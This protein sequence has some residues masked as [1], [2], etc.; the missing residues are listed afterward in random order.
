MDFQ[1]GDVF[2]N[3]KKDAGLQRTVELVINSILIVLFVL[4]IGRT[5]VIDIMDTSEQKDELEAIATQLTAKAE[6]IRTAE[7][8]LASYESSYELL[9]EAMPLSPK[10]FDMLNQIQLAAETEGVAVDQISHQ[11]GNESTVEFNLI[12]G[13]K[14]DEVIKFINRVENL[15]RLIQ[16]EDI[17]I[18]AS[19]SPD[20][21]NSNQNNPDLVFTL[22]GTG[23]FYSEPVTVLETVTES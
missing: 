7:S 2:K 21:E 1:I 22:T 6:S 5:V 9:A 13:G 18:S 14:Y 15:P 17:A 10:Q 23:Y 11:S 20:S 4:T 19:T 12:G 3:F 16:L 8:N